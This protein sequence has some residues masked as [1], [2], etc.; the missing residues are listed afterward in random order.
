MDYVSYFTLS[1]GVSEQSCPIS[2]KKWVRLSSN[3][4]NLGLF[5]IRF[6]TFGLNEPF[7]TFDLELIWPTMAKYD[8]PV[9]LCLC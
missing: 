9:C 3:M 6:S 2:A 1:I 4:T 8:N 7:V 5:Q